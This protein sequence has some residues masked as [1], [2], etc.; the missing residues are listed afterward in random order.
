MKISGSFRSGLVAVGVASLLGAG[1]LVAPAAHADTKDDATK[2]ISALQGKI[3]S[4]DADRG[5][6]NTGLGAKEGDLQ[7]VGDGF[8]QAF[9]GGTIFWSAKDGAQVLY[10]AIDEKFGE[11]GGPN[12]ASA[13]GFPVESEKNASFQ[14]GREAGFAGEGDPTIYW[15]PENGAWLVR[16]PMALAADKLGAT[17]GAPTGEMTVNGDELSQ[18]FASGTLTYNVKDKKWGSVPGSLAAGL[19]GLS[20]PAAWKNLGLPGINLPSLNLPDVNLP[21]ISAPNVSL[22][23]VSAPNVNL[24]DVNAPNVDAKGIS[25]WWWLLLLIPL[26]ALLWWLLTRNR[27]KDETTVVHA[28]RPVAKANLPKVDLPKA[29]LPNVDL[30]KVNLKGAATGA[31]AGVAAGAAAAAAAAKAKGAA[32]ADK[33]EDATTTTVRKIADSSTTVIKGGGDGVG[34]YVRAGKTVPVPVGAHL[35]LADPNKAPEGYDIKGNADSGLYHVP[36]SP[37]YKQTIAEIWFATEAAAKAAGFEPP[38]NA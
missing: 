33:V 27:R 36:G 11:L 26:L 13:I 23:N 35:P 14:P 2:A 22:P 28:A 31:A 15:T 24:P 32:A 16:G 37:S 4:G 9:D 7:A 19:A 1:A 18:T 34:N 29:D 30:P 5:F 38:K 8:S 12:G 20:I 17:L 25:P 3:S 10:G 21:N 6:N